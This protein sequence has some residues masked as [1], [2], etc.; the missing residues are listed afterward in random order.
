VLET[1]RKVETVRAGQNAMVFPCAVADRYGYPEKIMGYDAPG[2]MGVLAKRMKTKAWELI[3]LPA[4]TRYSLSQW[5]AFSGRYVTAWS[6]WELA[7]GTLRLLMGADENPHPTVWGWGGGTALAELELA[8][9]HG[10]RTVMLSG[11]DRRIA[12]IARTGVTPLDRRA[13]GDLTFD[14]RKFTTDRSARRTYLNAESAFLKAVK[15]QTEG[16][17]VNIFVDHIGTPVLRATM[18]AL[19]REGVIATAGWKEGQVISF[20]R[21]MECIARHQHVHTHYARY[22]QG[23]DAMAYAERHGWMPQLNDR[24]YS[25][26]EIPELAE[27]FIHG[28]HGLFPVFSVNS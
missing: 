12:E 23:V 27:R 19:S 26:D 17:G 3:P 4:N 2:T 22:R 11:N 8:K 9:R 25:F 10:C 5:A 7:F 14:E 24:A 28:D 21:A 16:Q 18:K 20:L 13:F 1:G 6:N 15:E